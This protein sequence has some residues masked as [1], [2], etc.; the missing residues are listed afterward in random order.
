MDRSVAADAM[1]HDD[2]FGNA[3][4]VLPPRAH[5]FFKRV[6]TEDLRE[7]M[8]NIYAYVAHVPKTAYSSYREVRSHYFIGTVTK[9]NFPSEDEIEVTAYVPR[10]NQTETTHLYQR[11][12]GGSR[13]IDFHP[14]EFYQ[15]YVWVRQPLTV[16]TE[17][18]VFKNRT[19]RFDSLND[20]RSKDGNDYCISTVI[21]FNTDDKT[22]V[23]WIEVQIEEAINHP[24]VRAMYV[25]EPVVAK[26]QRE[27]EGIPPMP[28]EKPNPQPQPDG[29]GEDQGK[30]KKPDDIPPMPGHAKNQTDKDTRFEPAGE[31]GA[32]WWGTAQGE[33]K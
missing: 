19:V 23:T 15:E 24:E 6:P 27:A 29:K 5:A 25:L 4:E 7:G 2:F 18:S 12:P 14:V 32:G 11:V 31:L 28:G 9:I 17:V 22:I 21:D 8:E 13:F 33:G 1:L 3:P 20:A 30:D 16:A 26:A 10:E